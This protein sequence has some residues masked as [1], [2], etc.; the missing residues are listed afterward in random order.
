MAFRLFLF[1]I[2]RSQ[3]ESVYKSVSEWSTLS[4]RENKE[5]R[6]NAEPCHKMAR[7]SNNQKSKQERA[8]TSSSASE[9]TSEAS[10]SSSSKATTSTKTSS[11]ATSPQEQSQS[12]LRR[13]S[14]KLPLL[15]LDVDVSRSLVLT[16]G[17][18]GSAKTG[19]KNELVLLK[20]DAAKA[21]LAVCARFDVGEFALSAVAAH[22]TRLV[23]AFG[24]AN[25]VAF[26]QFSALDVGAEFTPLASFACETGLDSDGIANEVRALAFNR[27]ATRLASGGGDGVVRLWQAGD[28]AKASAFAKPIAELSLD[29]VDV[30]VVKFS[31]DDSLLLGVTTARLRIWKVA[32]AQLIADVECPRASASYRFRGAAFLPDGRHVVTGTMRPTVRRVPGESVATVWRIDTE[33]RDPSKALS[34]VEAATAIRQQHHT[35]LA[36]ST[37]GK[38]VVTG[39]G[40]GRVS[41]LALLESSLRP[42]MV[43]TEAHGWVTTHVHAEPSLIVSVSV[44]HT[45]TVTRIERNSRTISPTTIALCV[46]LLLVVLLTIWFVMQ[47]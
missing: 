11:P 27:A 9:A 29:G 18:G 38:H 21:Q 36:V 22:P 19:I 13:V 23:A 17:G 34:V 39:T 10:S 12:D 43:L 5:N 3:R 35:A 24:A 28:L 4:T 44:D 32:S 47:Q 26:L 33:Q 7:K 46:A 25:R 16:G 6:T 31:P 14:L 41:S 15:A 45:I 42:E 30:Q 8:E 40:N 37:D 20:L 2:K 1:D